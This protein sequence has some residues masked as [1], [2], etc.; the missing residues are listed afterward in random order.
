MKLLHYVGVGLLALSLSACASGAR[1]TQNE[2]RQTGDYWQRNESVSAQYLTGPK[3]QH[4][5]NSDIAS[6]VAEVRELVRLG[7]IRGAQPPR[8]LAN[9]TNLNRAW[10]APHRDGPLYTEYTDFQDFEGCMVSKGWERTDFVR[11]VQAQRASENYANTILGY[12]FGY[13]PKDERTTNS[14]QDVNF[15][16]KGTQ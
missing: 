13:Y 10:A 11:P 1:E 12:T 14:K 15:N 5:L 9:E 16:R 6:C 4:Q 8:D 2:V 3:A 7:S